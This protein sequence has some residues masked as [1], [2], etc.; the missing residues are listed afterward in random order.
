[1]DAKAIIESVISDLDRK[2]SVIRGMEIKG[3]RA[4][5]YVA[6]KHISN[7]VYQLEAI[8]DRMEEKA[9]GN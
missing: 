4:G 9:N 1:M 3:C 5:L 7:A 8:L 2:R 6:H